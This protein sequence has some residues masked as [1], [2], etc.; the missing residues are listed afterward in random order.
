MHIHYIN[1]DSAPQ[2]REALE[3]SFSQTSL[4]SGWALS[5]FTAVSIDDERVKK[6]AGSCS[7]NEKACFLSHA[8]L[9]KQASESMDVH[10]IVEDDARFWPQSF[11]AV[12]TFI[13]NNEEVEWDILFTD[14]TIR[15]FGTMVDLYLARQKISPTQIE[16]IDIGTCPFCSA[17]SYVINPNSAKKVAKVLAA[18]SSINKPWDIH[19]ASAVQEGKLNAFF[20]LPFVTSLTPHAQS[21][22]I[23]DMPLDVAAVLERSFRNLLSV[24][25]DTQLIK[26]M[27]NQIDTKFVDDKAD[28]FGKIMAGFMSEKFPKV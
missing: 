20:T 5:R 26:E 15:S 8:S 19:L 2:R 10:W 21:S 22:Q 4:L 23:R 13:E 27:L 28:C 3:T 25:P 1:L 11:A 6:I 7:D 14:I 18:P 12:S 16:Y 17:V 24:S 9:V